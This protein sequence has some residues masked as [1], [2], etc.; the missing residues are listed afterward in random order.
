MP[1]SAYLTA[2][3][4]VIVP[5]AEV[6]AVVVPEF[7]AVDMPV[8]AFVAAVAVVDVVAVLMFHQRHENSVF[9]KDHRL[10]ENAKN[11]EQEIKTALSIL[12][13]IKYIFLEFLFKIIVNSITRIYRCSS[14]FQD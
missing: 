3:M 6:E 2:T 9:C 14:A 4:T 8:P 1:V 13:V 11:L 10:F 7:A 5:V 12:L